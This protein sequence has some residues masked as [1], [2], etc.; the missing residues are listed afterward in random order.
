[1][2]YS[3]T[4]ELQPIVPSYHLRIFGDRQL[5]ELKSATLEV[6]HEVGIHCPSERSRRIYAEHGAQVDW[7]TQIVKFPP[8]VVIEAMSHAPRYYTMGARSEAHDLKLDG[9]A[10]YVATDGS[11][12]T[13]IDFETGER[14]PLALYEPGIPDLVADRGKPVAV[15]H[16]CHDPGPRLLSLTRSQASDIGCD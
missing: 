8:E 11:G 3:E 4:P 5:A 15:C 6:L 12:L 10:M 16:L 2:G 9:T 7:Q 14:R 13:T 1:M